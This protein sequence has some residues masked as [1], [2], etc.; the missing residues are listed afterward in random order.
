M[1]LR[2]IQA[3]CNADYSQHTTVA[4]LRPTQPPLAGM[5]A[6]FPLEPPPG[7]VE[8]PGVAPA[9][10]AQP[11]APPP[12][13]AQPAPGESTARRRRRHGRPLQRLFMCLAAQLVCLSDKLPPAL[14][15]QL[16]LHLPLCAGNRFKLVLELLA[17][18]E[19]M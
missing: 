18:V 19:L 4:G 13:G 3:D 11:A 7:L 8:L 6:G 16:Q 9:A 15:L 1:L 2:R 17:A 10:P 14:G 5:A 12:P